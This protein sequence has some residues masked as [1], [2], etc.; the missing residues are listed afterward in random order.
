M[1]SDWLSVSLK[2][3]YVLPGRGFQDHLLGKAFYLYSSDRVYDLSIKEIDF[4]CPACFFSRDL[5]RR[6]EKNT[7]LLLDSPMKIRSA[8]GSGY[9]SSKG[10]APIWSVINDGDPA[11]PLP[12]NH[13]SYPTYSRRFLSD[14]SI[15]RISSFLAYPSPWGKKL[16]RIRPRSNSNSRGTRSSR[17]RHQNR[18][19]VAQ[20]IPAIRC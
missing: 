2:D 7:T 17:L 6:R 18:F 14:R 15:E 11:L 8:L 9:L 19:D 5:S 1:I 4:L 12:R 20:W 10:V 3:R 16:D 13:D